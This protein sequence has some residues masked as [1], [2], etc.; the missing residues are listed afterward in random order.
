MNHKPIF[1]LWMAFLLCF[2]ANT[3]AQKQVKQTDEVVQLLKKYDAAWNK[4]D[5]GTVAKILS[6]E[7]VYFTSTGGTSDYQQTLDFLKSPKYNLTFAE[8][9]EIKTFRTGNTVVVSSR[10]KGKGT[11]NDEEIN[12]DQRCGQVFVK[13]GKQWKLAAEHCTQ[14]V[15][16]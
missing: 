7:Y 13:K 14:I 11:Y 3:N 15:S 5:S 2:S 12:D 10:W 16:K 4:K 8:R 9:S 1:L 6:S